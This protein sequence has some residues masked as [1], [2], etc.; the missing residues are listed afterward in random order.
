MK[1]SSL[2]QILGILV[3]LGIAVVAY[4][5]PLFGIMLMLIG[6]ICIIILSLLIFQIALEEL[7]R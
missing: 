3:V 6:A 4:I 5:Y 2:I 1:K 7:D